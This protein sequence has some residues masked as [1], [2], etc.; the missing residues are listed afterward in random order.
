MHAIEEEYLTVAEAAAPAR[1][2]FDL[3]AA[4]DAYYL[5]LSRVLGREF[6]TDDQ[7]LLQQV[8]DRLPSVRPLADFTS[9][10]P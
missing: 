3:P 8:G 5:A 7:R 9:A 4:Y 1:G 10:E 2:P 6:W